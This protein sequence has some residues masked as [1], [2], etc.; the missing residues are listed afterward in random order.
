M[1]SPGLL[2]SSG[3]VVGT[4]LAGGLLV[5]TAV[6]GL[7]FSMAHAVAI[8]FPSCAI[9]PI[10]ALVMGASFGIVA[11][12]VKGMSLAL[13]RKFPAFYKKHQ[14]LLDTIEQ[15]IMTVVPSL[16]GF[17][18]SHALGYGLTASKMVWFVLASIPTIALGLAILAGLALLVYG[19]Y[20][21]AMRI[22]NLLAPKPVSI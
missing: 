17:M 19:I 10:N 5:G 11:G 6:G 20:K 14:K 9:S 8:I 22:S 7:G 13:S 21:G 4:S 12:A 18:I 3:E 1:S 2:K 15:I 16:G